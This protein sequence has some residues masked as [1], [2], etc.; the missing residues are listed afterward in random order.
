[1]VGGRSEAA[2]RRIGR[3]GDGWVSY[4]V[5]PEQYVLRPGDALGGPLFP[6]ILPHPIP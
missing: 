4:V 3:M 1:M 2:L 5:T 6:Q